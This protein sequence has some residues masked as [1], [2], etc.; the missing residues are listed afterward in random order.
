VP[1][2]IGLHL[3][4]WLAGKFDSR[5]HVLKRGLG[6]EQDL[7]HVADGRNLLHDC[8]ALRCDR[9]SNVE[10][11][12]LACF[13]PATHNRIES[14]TQMLTFDIDRRKQVPIDAQRPGFSIC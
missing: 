10:K 13:V 1:F 9:H 6:F 11:V 8:F 4:I 7:V 2:Q 3:V 12:I 14:E 5:L